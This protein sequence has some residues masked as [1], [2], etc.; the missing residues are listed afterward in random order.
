MTKLNAAGSAKLY[1]TYLGSS[2]FDWA[3]GI[4]IDSGGNAYVA[5]Y[6]SSAGFPVVGGVQAGFNGF[7]DA[8]VSKLNPLG[9]GLTFS[10][11]YG[12][13]GADQ[14]NAIAVDTSGNM[15]IGGQTSSLDL[16]LQGAIQSFNV[17]G[18][19]GWVA[20][21]GVTAPPPQ[22]P[23]ANSVSPSSG[24]G[25]TVTFTAQYSHPAGAGSL[26]AV[27]LLLNTTASLNFACYVTYNPATN[28]FALAN[29]DASTGS[30]SVTPGGG[31]GANNQC[32]L[33]GA[34]SSASIAG[35]NLTL[36]V[37][38]TFQPGFAG[39]KTVYLYAAD[40]V[41]NTGFL[42][43]GTW[44]VTIPPPVPSVD[45]VSPNASTGAIQTF[46][47]RL[48]RHTKRLEPDQHGHV[49][50]HLRESCQF[51]LH[52]LRSRCRIDQAFYR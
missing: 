43:K 51:L 27:A 41:T 1:S 22:L 36:T 26:T 5:G 35:T 21:L 42:A 13:T 4:A 47:V 29:D 24:S 15:F 11:L 23:A 3:S 7:Y 31:S 50:Q 38:L 37:S 40:A 32:T 12:G 8:F 14:A 19:T 20:R 44:S 34:G 16:P 9:N 33:N 39:D 52:R 17:G 28:L 25:N 45:S 18:S 49:V 10:T 46:Y 30:V 6:T 48:L 2:S